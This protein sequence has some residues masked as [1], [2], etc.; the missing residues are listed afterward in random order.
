MCCLR[1]S[2]GTLKRKDCKVSDGIASLASILARFV[3]LM[4]AMS[5]FVR[6]RTP[7]TWW[8]TPGSQDSHNPP[9]WDDYDIIAA[10]LAMSWK[11]MSPMMRTTTTTSVD[12]RHFNDI[13]SF[14]MFCQF[15]FTLF[16][17]EY[18]RFMP[19]SKHGQTCLMRL[20]LLVHP[21][22]LVLFLAAKHRLESRARAPRETG[23][24]HTE[25]TREGASRG[26]SILFGRRDLRLRGRSAH[27]Q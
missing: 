7:L 9:G 20:E 10:V 2:P 17:D 12:F 3:L 4:D 14:A 11:K 16:V 18:N 5:T 23:N 8:M 26:G 24:I 13:R 19:R 1:R 22:V 27:S 21:T 25:T 6:V 15:L